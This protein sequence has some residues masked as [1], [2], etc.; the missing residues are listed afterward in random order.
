MSDVVRLIMW[1]VAHNSNAYTMAHFLG[2]PNPIESR[3]LWSGAAE[4]RGQPVE[5]WGQ[6]DLETRILLDAEKVR[7]ARN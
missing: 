2:L 3:C 6:C 7:H 5:V 1:C 4:E